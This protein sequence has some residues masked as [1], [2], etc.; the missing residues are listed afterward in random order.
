MYRKHKS[1]ALAAEGRSSNDLDEM[2]EL[3][4]PGGSVNQDMTTGR[5]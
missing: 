3:H 1:K 2:A 4:I 5:K